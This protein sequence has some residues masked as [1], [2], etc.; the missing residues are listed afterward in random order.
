MKIHFYNSSLYYQLKYN[1]SVISFI[2]WLKC[3]LET[4][5]PFDILL[6][7]VFTTCTFL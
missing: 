7:P 1:L 4:R 5:L 3:H 2:V 6:E